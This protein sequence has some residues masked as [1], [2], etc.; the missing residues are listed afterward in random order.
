[1]VLIFSILDLTLTLVISYRFVYMLS[2][3]NRLISLVYI[4]RVLMKLSFGVIWSHLW[5]SQSQKRIIGYNRINVCLYLL[6][7]VLSVSLHR[8]KIKLLI[9][10]ALSLC[11]SSWD[12]YR[13]RYRKIYDTYSNHVRQT[14]L[15]YYGSHVVLMFGIV[16]SAEY[17][18]K[19]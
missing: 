17:I 18:I 6:F 13:A 4:T 7:E 16:A 5:F 1:M 8:F 14:R 9:I 3:H 19:A 12:L 11:I 10:M 2:P 15:V